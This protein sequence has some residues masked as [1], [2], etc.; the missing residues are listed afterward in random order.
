[1]TAD[2]IRQSIEF[3]LNMAKK[4]T[5]AYMGILD[6]MK[7]FPRYSLT[8]QLCFHRNPNAI[9]LASRDSWI[10]YFKLPIDDKAVGMEV[11][12]SNKNNKSGVAV[13]YDITDT[14]ST[15][16]QRH[17]IVL[18]KIWE[19]HP[20]TDIKLIDEALG[21]SADNNIA[22]S[23]KVDKIVDAATANITEDKELIRESFAYIF[24][25]SLQL[26]VNFNKEIP[27]PQDIHAALETIN[28]LER[29]II[30]P[31][32]DQSNHVRKEGYEHLEEG[33]F[34]KA[35]GQYAPSLLN[36]REKGN[37]EIDSSKDNGKISDEVQP[38]VHKD[39]E[40]LDAGDVRTGTLPTSNE[41]RDGEKPTEDTEDKAEGRTGEPETQNPKNTQTSDEP[42]IAAVPDR[43]GD[44]KQNEAGKPAEEA[45]DIKV[46][47]QDEI[48][49]LY[50]WR[51]EIE[52][53]VYLGEE[54]ELP[55]PLH[56][57][58][59]YK[60]YMVRRPPSPGA[61]PD[62]GLLRVDRRDEGR[63][64]ISGGD[65]NPNRRYYGAAYYNRELT[66]EELKEHEMIRGEDLLQ[67]KLDTR[68]DEWLYSHYISDAVRFP[69]RSD[70]VFA[71]VIPY[72]NR[73][74]DINELILEPEFYKSHPMTVLGDL[75]DPVFNEVGKLTGVKSYD[76][77]TK[78]TDAEQYVPVDEIRKEYT[79]EHSDEYKTASE[80]ETIESIEITQTIDEPVVTEESKQN[81]GE[82]NK[83]EIP[84]EGI[85]A[86]KR[87]EQGTTETTEA[88]ETT[89]TTEEKPEE[90]K[91]ETQNPVSEIN[92]EGEPTTP[93]EATATDK[94]AEGKSEHSKEESIDSKRAEE[95]EIVNGLTEESIGDLVEQN[96]LFADLAPLDN[97]ELYRVAL[98]NIK[99]KQG[100]IFTDPLGNNIYFAP[101]ST[102]TLE[103]YALHLVAG[104]GK[105]ISDVRLKR[106]AG[107]L[108]SDETIKN[109]WAIIVQPN[110][111]KMYLKIYQSGNNF[112]NA[113]IVGVEEGQ[114][115][116]VVTSTVTASDR[117]DKRAAMREFK[118]RISGSKEIIYIWE[119][120]SRHLRP[121]SEQVISQVDAHLHPIG[122]S[123]VPQP[124]EKSNT[125][126]T[127]IL[128]DALLNIPDFPTIRS[129][130]ETEDKQLIAKAMEYV[131]VA[132]DY[133]TSEAEKFSDIEAV[134]R[135]LS[136]SLNT[137]QDR[138]ARR[139]FYIMHGNVDNDEVL[140]K[141]ILGLKRKMFEQE[142]KNTEIVDAPLPPTSGGPSGST[143]QPEPP[144]S[145]TIPKK[146]LV[147][148]KKTVFKD[149]VAAIRTL[150]SLDERNEAHPTDEE[151]TVMSKYR[152]FGG[153]ADVFN[154]PPD[155]SWKKEQEELK[156]LLTIKEYDDLKESVLSSYYTPPEVIKEIYAGLEHIGFHKGNILEPSCGT[157]SFI[158]NMP[159]DIKKN[160]GVYGIELNSI[161]GGIAQKLNSDATIN[162]M[163]YEDAHY[164]R[165]SFDLAITNVP[166]GEYK[167]FD[168]AYPSSYVHDYF[169]E[170]MVDQVRDD[171]LVA[172][173]TTSG[174]MDKK[175]N[176]VRKRLA[177][178]A[179]LVTAIRLPNSTFNSAGTKVVTDLLVFKRRL[180]ER[181]FKSDEELP[182]WAKEPVELK[183]PDTFAQQF[184]INPYFANHPENVAGKLSF[185]R[186]QFG[187]GKVDILPNDDVPLAN[188][189][190]QVF[191]SLPEIYK[192]SSDE[193]EI[194]TA[195]NLNK[196]HSLYR[197]YVEHEH[198]YFQA[199]NGDEAKEI[200]GLSEKDKKHLIS[201][202]DLA[203]EIYHIFDLQKNNCSDEVL[204][205]EQAKLSRLYDAYVQNYDYIHN[206][207]F[208]KTT[209]KEDASIPL[210]SS[211]CSCS[212]NLS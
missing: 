162:V 48:L 176:S 6:T 13:V 158:S 36:G 67:A 72:I 8:M 144:A 32:Q 50:P 60:Y 2:E 97:D 5:F 128:P 148:G 115:G 7:K 14:I 142:M 58:M 95:L 211:L 56:G 151:K 188:K 49:N 118:K 59:E 99:N 17:S 52:N 29:N 159:D 163:G 103:G 208:L 141:A 75:S 92:V 63:P 20:D 90:E 41:E 83:T 156:S 134:S 105:S 93:T 186:D 157:G 27:M 161:A 15:A 109:P 11:L 147:Y 149:N 4:N 86:P 78:W 21:L 30:I 71:E 82:K 123:S 117:K 197:F 209:M 89:E 153:L 22:L 182:E 25:K 145:D 167:V 126:T 146:A 108:V 110:G 9:A 104:Q 42:T 170:K 172:V 120:L 85:S 119:G 96:S 87:E 68:L 179:D 207:K 62:D 124:N 61:Q 166:F 111:R 35:L 81:E 133:F 199:G 55:N 196:P 175:D 65:Y 1:M 46:P 79:K 169:I 138:F 40:N 54:T 194:G 53:G 160:S 137:L 139:A 24:K 45:S 195:D 180:E 10:H 23:E 16:E 106:V 125:A 107:V 190:H 77:Y 26:P 34:F 44:E 136:L 57:T 204:M 100:K 185:T 37:T 88:T 113:L 98:E 76:L 187:K 198:V 121:S 154:D 178:K 73:G 143:N 91:K 3:N 135:E 189:I 94:N 132:N 203:N 165:N 80:E 171:G 122:N 183:A 19:F 47:T 168:P 70:I 152:G 212:R 192:E 205:T 64:G 66:Q 28:S 43:P 33:Q 31:F 174:T 210:L 140:A 101:G 184:T 127:N 202:I 191:E 131:K 200:T 193:H 84:K 201:A 129:I 39:G 155:D 181:T 130:N 164:Y 206:D 102:E 12:D 38:E 177:E 112:N 51:R 69:L 114:N 74:A 150:K 173:I 116:R 18:N